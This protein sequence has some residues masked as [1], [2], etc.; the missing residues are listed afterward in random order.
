MIS[1]Q[2]ISRAHLIHKGCIEGVRK[3]KIGAQAVGRGL[4]GLELL[5]VRAAEYAQH[6]R[7]VRRLELR[8]LNAHQR[9]VTC[10]QTRKRAC[11]YTCL[12]SIMTLHHFLAFCLEINICLDK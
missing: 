5:S 2:I 11:S 12:L 8:H 3:V 4:K 9:S 1:S 7:V 10:A 6:C